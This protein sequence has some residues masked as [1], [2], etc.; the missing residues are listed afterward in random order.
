MDFEDKRFALQFGLERSMLYHRRR[1]DFFDLLNKSLAFSQILLGSYTANLVLAGNA[2]ALS[3]IGIII[4]FIGALTL[5]GDFGAC[6]KE[7][8]Y[9]QKHFNDLIIKIRKLAINDD[10]GLDSIACERLSLE[11]EEPAIYRALDICCHNALV[12]AKGCSPDELCKLSAIQG[13]LRHL[14]RFESLRM[15]LYAPKQELSV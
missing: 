10:T 9:L 11:A 8:Q 4:A 13:M 6:A 14:R 12:Q 2:Y 1:R 3:L 5:V 7:H 15:G